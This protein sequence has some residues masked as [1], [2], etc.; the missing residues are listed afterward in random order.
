[1]PRP[2]AASTSANVMRVSHT[3]PA[4]SSVVL[5]IGALIAGAAFIA[6]MLFTAMLAFTWFAFVAPAAGG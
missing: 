3:R 4:R 6:A 1:M 2:P 5:L